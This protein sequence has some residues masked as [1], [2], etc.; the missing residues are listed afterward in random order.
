[1]PCTIKVTVK[2]ALNLPPMDVLHGKCDAYVTIHF[3]P[4]TAKTQVSPRTLNPE[5]NQTLRLEVSNDLELMDNELEC[6]VWDKDIMSDDTIGSVIVDLNCLLATHGPEKIHGWFPIYDTIKGIRGYLELSVRVHFFSD[7]NFEASDV[8]LFSVSN[9]DGFQIVEVLGLVE[10]LMVRQDPE[11]QWRDRIRT[12]RASN[13]KRMR[14]LNQ[15]ANK[16]DRCIAERTL[17][18]GGNAVLGYQQIIDLEEETTLLTAKSYGTACK[19]RHIDSSHISRKFPPLFRHSSQHYVLE[20]HSPTPTPI[21]PISKSIMHSEVL[22]LTL[23]SIPKGCRI[24]FGS[25]VSS[26]SVKILRNRSRGDEGKTHIRDEWWKEIRSE[27]RQHARA[28]GCDA[29]FGYKEATAIY[30]DVCVLTAQGTAA[31]LHEDC[32]ERFPPN[33]HSSL[34]SRSK[35]SGGFLPS[36][37]SMKRASGSLGTSHLH[38]KT[39]EWCDCMWVHAPEAS[40]LSPSENPSICQIC[41][42]GQVHSVLLSTLELPPDLP[43]TGSCNLLQARTCRRLKRVDPT[44]ITEILPFLTFDLHRQFMYKLR[45]SGYNAAFRV[46]TS[47]SV[48]KNLIIGTLTASAVCCPAIPQ[49]TPLQISRNIPRIDDE[50]EELFQLQKTLCDLSKENF[51]KIHDELESWKSSS[52]FTN[53]KKPV[54]I[55]SLG[56]LLMEPIYL[57]ENDDRANTLIMQIDDEADEDILTALSDPLFPD[58]MCFSNLDNPPGLDEQTLCDL[59]F[60]SAVRRVNFSDVADHLL[61]RE[62]SRIFHELHARIAFQVRNWGLAAVCG[63]APK[64][65]IPEENVAQVFVSCVALKLEPGQVRARSFPLTEKRITKSHV[66]EVNPSADLQMENLKDVMISFTNSNAE[67]PP[68][69]NPD[70]LVKTLLKKPKPSDSD[71][72]EISPA[73]LDMKQMSDPNAFEPASPD[74]VMP[75]PTTFQEK[76]IFTGSYSDTG[77]FDQEETEEEE[78]SAKS[79]LFRRHSAPPKNPIMIQQKRS[80]DAT[81]PECI[82]HHSRFFTPMPN[83]PGTK[84][85]KYCGRVQLFFIKEAIG[86][87]AELGL[88]TQRFLEEVQ[89]MARANVIARGG[90]ALIDFEITHF[91]LEQESAKEAYALVGLSGDA[92]KVIDNSKSKSETK[93][94]N[95]QSEP[96]E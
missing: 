56:P 91:L 78:V 79:S 13:Q 61:V 84:I 39:K 92:V 47:I 15:L 60:I 89:S 10:E 77:T 8:K 95:D 45:L 48:G 43:I 16:I 27:I 4:K 40:E 64:L 36:P 46:K 38:Q 26:Y 62:F 25:L 65:S 85:A 74:P 73:V 21:N 41:H 86:R 14:L 44:L 33:P 3:G 29:V 81:L 19:I 5:W 34:M 76:D 18:M 57:N 51:Q 88:F 2:R 66:E 63:L 1:M 24:N 67:S 49:A 90:N 83:L 87:E 35:S 31:K 42:N 37:N 52:M 55:P 17:E 7:A 58:S 59:K 23:D 30:D 9:P 11:F 93:V 20:A 53:K 69:E 82:G 50:D 54:N 94:C 32:S 68:T 28:Q 71:D 12:K 96:L 22:L 80:D 70:D 6:K 72:L 75:D